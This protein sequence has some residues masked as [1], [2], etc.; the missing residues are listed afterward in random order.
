MNNCPNCGN[1][2]KPNDRFCTRCGA[3]INNASSSEPSFSNEPK[4]DVNE[5]ASNAFNGAKNTVM[6]TGR[7]GVNF[8]VRRYF[9]GFGDIMWLSVIALIVLNILNGTFGISLYYGMNA[10]GMLCT[11]LQFITV[12]VFIGAFVLNIYARVVGM[13][14][15]DVDEATRNA[16]EMLKARAQ[17]KFNVDSEQINEVE[18]VVI[19]GAGSSPI[20]FVAGVAVRKRFNFSLLKKFYSKEPLEAYRLGRDRVPRYLLIQTTVYAFTDTQLLV[21]NGN[22]DISTGGVYEESTAEIFYNDVNSITQND[23]LKKFKAGIF[24]K[25]YYLLKYLQLDVCGVSKIASFDS[26]FAPNANRSLAGMKT[27]I[28]E[29]KF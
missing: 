21:Y 25:E 13:G 10:F 4:F 14:K 20:E 27:Y 12:I 23:I 11:V 29:K 9:F 24:R 7:N 1:E 18:P 16:I 8:M 19:A 6:G 26:R 28:R 22:V 5:F 2:L 3:Q 17:T 15:K